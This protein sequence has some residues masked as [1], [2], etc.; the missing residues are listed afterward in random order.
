MECDEYCPAGLVRNELGVG[1]LIGLDGLLRRIL[2]DA[3][4]ELHARP[5][6]IERAEDR[7]TVPVLRTDAP[8]GTSVD[9]LV[10]DQSPVQVDGYEVAVAAVL[11]ETGDRF[12]QKFGFEDDDADLV[13]DSLLIFAASVQ[14]VISTE[15]PTVMRFFVDS[16]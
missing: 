5:E 3:Q 13:T 14:R 7:K 16:M 2:L 6:G 1:F 9:H 8:G 15:L 4:L 10:L 12:V 11:F